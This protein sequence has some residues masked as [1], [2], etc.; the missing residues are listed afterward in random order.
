MLIAL[1]T[2]LGRTQR[3]NRALPFFGVSTVEIAYATVR[4]LEKKQRSAVILLNAKDEVKDSLPLELFMRQV[5]EVASYSSAELG[6]QVRVPYDLE[7]IERLAATNVPSLLID[8]PDNYNGQEF[9]F[10]HYAHIPLAAQLPALRP[11]AIVHQLVRQSGIFALSLPLITE[12]KDK[13]AISLSYLK[14]LQKEVRIPL[15]AQ[16]AD[17]SRHV[18]KWAFPAGIAGYIIN[19]ELDQAYTSGLRASLRNRFL[20]QP[21]EYQA[22]AMDAV[23]QVVTHYLEHIS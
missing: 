19:H 15:I 7:L 1:P 18:L 21:A 10:P 5:V 17:L 12:Y 20:D 4:A 14:E 11:A 16:E 8:L 2:L 6:M 9:S 23:E 3:S 22:K 13:P